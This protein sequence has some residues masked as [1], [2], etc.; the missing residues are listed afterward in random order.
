MLNKEQNVEPMH[1]SP[2]DAKLP[3]SGSLP[4]EWSPI[5]S[6][7]KWQQEQL[8]RIFTNINDDQPDWQRLNFFIHAGLKY[9]GL[10]CNDR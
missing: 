5:E 2:A 10:D 1:V 8:A 6:E 7:R 4:L 3:V 9:L